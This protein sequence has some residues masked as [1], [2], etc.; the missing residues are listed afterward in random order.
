MAE[1]FFKTTVAR[2]AAGGVDSPRLETRLL[3]AFAANEPA[4]DFCPWRELPPTV[5]EKAEKLIARRLAHE[6]LDKIVGRRSFY[7]YDFAVSKDVLSPRPDSEVLVEAAAALI[8]EHDWRTVLDL[9]TGSGCLLLSLLADFPM[10]S[11]CGADVSPAAL[12]VAAKNARALGVEKRAEL[13]RFDY[14]ADDFDR[15]FDLIVSNPPY[16]PTNDIA[17]LDAEVRC[18]DPLLALDGGP[19]GLVHYRRLAE[20]TPPLL[21]DGGFILLEGG[22]GQAHL[23][24]GIFAAAGLTPVSILSDL[25]GIERCIILKK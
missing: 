9:G 12:A 20:I 11:G 6:P 25:S 2:L 1:D 5:R 14:F 23:I 7:K 17:G 16:I 15:R 19:D 24:S 4:E 13:L 10:L 8:K 22:Q 21:N 18:H 3:L